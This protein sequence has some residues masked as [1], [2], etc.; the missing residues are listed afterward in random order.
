MCHFS[1]IIFFLVN[2]NASGYTWGQCCH[3]QNDGASLIGDGRDMLLC[4]LSG[5]DNVGISTI[6]GSLE[7]LLVHTCLSFWSFRNRFGL[8]PGDRLSHSRSLHTGWATSF[9]PPGPALTHGRHEACQ[10][11]STIWWEVIA[12]R[13]L[14]FDP[15]WEPPFCFF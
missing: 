14:S 6:K 4:D 15:V 13:L 9:G 11:M 12:R 2:Q 1:Q 5:K 8:F 10:R 3:Q 7:G